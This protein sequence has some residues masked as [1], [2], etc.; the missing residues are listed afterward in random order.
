[1]HAPPVVLQGEVYL[2]G[3]GGGGD[4]R[5]GGPK[6][7]EEH[8]REKKAAGARRGC[9]F[10][11]GYTWVTG[12]GQTRMAWLQFIWAFLGRLMWYWRSL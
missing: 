1:M 11:V 6:M 7:V 4:E 12:N 9:V 2:V 3:I 8:E 5:A 10:T